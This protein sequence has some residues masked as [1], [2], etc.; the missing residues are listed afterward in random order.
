[1]AEDFI[2]SSVQPSP[3]L[4]ATVIACNFSIQRLSVL[5]AFNTKPILKEQMKC[6]P[7]NVAIHTVLRRLLTVIKTRERKDMTV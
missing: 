2:C 5:F 4:A 1:M 7:L 6:G 3:H